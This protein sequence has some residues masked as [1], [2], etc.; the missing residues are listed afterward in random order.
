MDSLHVYEIRVLM[1]FS[2]PASRVVWWFKVGIRSLG[3]WYWAVSSNYLGRT[4]IEEASNIS[5]R[6]FRLKRLDLLTGGGGL[7]SFAFSTF[8]FSYVLRLAQ[9]LFSFFIII[10]IYIFFLIIRLQQSNTFFRNYIND[11]RMQFH[12]SCVNYLRITDYLT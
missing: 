11:T 2:S 8:Y 5:T 6:Y 1:S 7:F 12:F 10:T 4:I 3:F 9:F